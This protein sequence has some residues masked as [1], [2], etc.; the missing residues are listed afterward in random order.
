M[1]SV[2][3][4]GEFQLHKPGTVCHHFSEGKNEEP[5]FERLQVQRDEARA[6][7][8]SSWERIEM[9]KQKRAAWVGNI[10]DVCMEIPT[11]SK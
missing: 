2:H 3:G 9:Q 8:V 1:Y 11:V 4:G 6:A 5:G 10:G 7:Q